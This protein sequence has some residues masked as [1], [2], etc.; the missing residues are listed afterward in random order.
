[1]VLEE[2][3]SI[4]K[5]LVKNYIKE[6]SID[7]LIENGYFTA[8]ASTKYHLAY[9][10][11]L[12]I[13]S[14]NVTVALNDLTKKLGLKWEKEESPILIGI[15]H[16]LCKIDAYKLVDGVYVYNTDAPKGH[17]DKSVDYI[18][19]HINIGREWTEEELDCIRWHM[20][21]FD[22][23]DNWSKYSDA[24]LKHENVLWTHTADMMA[25][26]LMEK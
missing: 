6:E 8:P 16:D 3:I 19:E 20:G 25:S 2:R 10:G 7:W 22:D 11:G 24:I 18:K 21:A 17:G 13:H 15:F 12:F 1:M 5:Y 4:F 23:K 14:L 26:K 9:E